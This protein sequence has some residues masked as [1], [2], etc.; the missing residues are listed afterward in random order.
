ML[1]KAL[2]ILSVWFVN[3][4]AVYSK[5]PLMTPKDV[6]V[7]GELDSYL[8]E[9]LL[10]SPDLG[11]EAGIKDIYTRESFKKLILKHDLQLFGGPMLGNLTDSGGSVWIRTAAPA[12]VRLIIDSKV[13]GT[14]RHTHPRR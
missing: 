4:L 9:E 14:A 11:N 6:P 3:L 12:E 13:N 10:R 1:Y 7:L 8:M 5:P 2:L